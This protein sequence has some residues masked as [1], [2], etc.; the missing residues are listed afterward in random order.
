MHFSR[1]Y[2]LEVPLS[3]CLLR[4]RSLCAFLPS[5]YNA[6]QILFILLFI[7]W[8]FPHYVLVACLFR[9]QAS[10][11]SFMATVLILIFASRS[12]LIFRFDLFSKRCMSYFLPLFSFWA[13]YFYIFFIFRVEP[14]FVIFIFDSEIQWIYHFAFIVRLSC[15]HLLLSQYSLFIIMLVR[16][17]FWCWYS[18]LG[19]VWFRCFVLLSR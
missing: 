13:L 10:L 7:C 17:V 12:P 2:I 5:S 1:F 6:V 4:P 18:I 3:F 19:P 9:F 8:P 15:L 14:L 11:F 16:F